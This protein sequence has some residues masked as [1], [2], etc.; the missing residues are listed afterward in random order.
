[1][2]DFEDFFNS[3]KNYSFDKHLGPV[4]Y[5]GADELCV[6]A[7]LAGYHQPKYDPEKITDMFIADAYSGHLGLLEEEEVEMS[8]R[9]IKEL[10][11]S[12]KTK[13]INL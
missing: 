3:M 10:I 13:G 6:H 7:L 1:M 11:D 4:P 9:L 2:D 12:A 5:S 8:L